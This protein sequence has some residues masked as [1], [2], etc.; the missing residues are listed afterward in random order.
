MST[1][2]EKIR[3][4]YIYSNDIEKSLSERGYD[5]S[6]YT[7]KDWANLIRTIQGGGSSSSEGSIVTVPDG[8]RIETINIDSNPVNNFFLSYSFKTVKT[9]EKNVS[10]AVS[11]EKHEIIPFTVITNIDNT[12]IQA[13]TNRTS[14]NIVSVF[15]K[16]IETVDVITEI[17][18][19]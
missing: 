19:V 17:E 13:L 1:L 2:A 6:F 5:M 4:L 7:M 14:I 15:T 8:T 11:L 3:E 9:N 16:E 12:K 10:S 18:E